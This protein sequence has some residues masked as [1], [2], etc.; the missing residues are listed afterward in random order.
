MGVAA[1][2]LDGA[3]SPPLLRRALAYEKWGVGDV[4]LLPAGLLPKITACLNVYH[5]VSGYLS[6]SGNTVKWTKR[7][8]Q[9][10]DL[11]SW[12]IS[13]RKKHGRTE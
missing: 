12:I 1:H 9:A 8:P 10:W 2:L 6:A 13:E 11:V 3:V 7:N 4:R 5:A